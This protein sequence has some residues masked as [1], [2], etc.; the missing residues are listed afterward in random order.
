M[1]SRLIAKLLLGAV[2]FACLCFL[3]EGQVYTGSGSTGSDGA[4]S[5]PNAH[6]GD[7]IIFNP[8][9]YTPPLDP[10]NDGIFNFTTISIPAGVTVKLTYPLLR[11]PLYWLATGNVD[12]EGTLDLSGGPGNPSTS[13]TALRVPSTPGP[14]G[15]PGGV[16]GD[17][18]AQYPPEPG[19]GP[20]GGSTG[21]NGAC[22]GGGMLGGNSLLVPLFGGSGGGGRSHGDNGNRFGAGGGAGGGAILIASSTT[23]TVNGSIL[24]NGGDS[25]LYGGG[26]A[27][28]AI[29]LLGQ[30]IS[31]NGVLQ[32]NGGGGGGCGQNGGAGSI[33]LEAYNQNFAG[34]SS[35]N[36]TSGTPFATFVPTAGNAAATLKVLSVGGVAVNP[37]PTG[38]FSVPDV[39]INSSSA[40]PVVVQAVNIPLGT[41]VHLQFWSENAPDMEVD[42]PGLSGTLASSSAT[43]NVTF[44]PGFSHGFVTATFNSQ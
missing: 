31:G 26:G 20:G 13:L 7:T 29:R 42:T 15:Y 41:V 32:T 8:A 36:L 18:S 12:I 34:S 1:Y 16:G 19:L 25:P 17:G 4:L 21:Y 5:F 10:S 43:A 35:S 28:G 23:I 2:L 39:T 24:S 30:T 44:P 22:G 33:R 9:S 38:S 11:G 3:A 27:G 6:P 40:V 14:G 37:N